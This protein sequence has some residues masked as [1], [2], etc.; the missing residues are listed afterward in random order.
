MADPAE[1]RVVIALRWLI[2][3]A[4][5]AAMPACAARPGEAV[6]AVGRDVPE[7]HRTVTIITAT[8][9]Q[10]DPAGIGYTAARSARLQFER[11]EVATSGA[12]KR[13]GNR[14]SEA[15]P[16]RAHNFVVTRRETVKAQ[17]LDV[18]NDILVYVH[19]Y[20][21]SFQEA[22]F[23]VARIAADGELKE[24][25]ILFSWPS[26]ARVTGYVADKAA[27]A[28]ARDD[29][30]ELLSSLVK[31]RPGGSVTLFGHSM[32]AWIVVESLRQ[33][34]LSGRENVL[35]RIDR[36][37]LAAP[38]IDVDLFKRQVDTIGR[39]ANPIMVLNSRDDRALGF[40]RR[41]GGARPRIG[42]VGEDNEIARELMARGAIEVVDLSML[43]APDRPRHN[44][45][46]EL[47]EML[48]GSEKGKK[49][50]LESGVVA[51]SIVTPAALNH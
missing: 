8:D 47:V 31:Q 24:T 21:Y 3:L 26:E 18:G 16:V 6:L 38:D 7:P 41:I 46:I 49:R 51:A 10:R 25:P 50:F 14:L 1:R 2:W 17:D 39:L 40:S 22:L 9:R 12:G 42:A 5:I 13:P 33:L 35:R 29:V 34:R 44:R 37:V 43:P 20:N 30:V 11:F 4:V 19:G 45:F 32:G 15:R 36:V 48:S 28:Y 23:Q 27:A